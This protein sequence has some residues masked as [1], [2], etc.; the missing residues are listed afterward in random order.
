MKPSYLFLMALACLV[1]QWPH[2]DKYLRAIFEPR[3]GKWRDPNQ[4]GVLAG[5]LW[6][7]ALIAVTSYLYSK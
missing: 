3:P 4:W 5:F 2:Y 7:Y 6:P 1:T